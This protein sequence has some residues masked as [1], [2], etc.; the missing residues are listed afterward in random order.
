MRWAHI[1]RITLYSLPVAIVCTG[2]WLVTA[3]LFGPRGGS[4]L[5]PLAVVVGAAASFATALVI[6]FAVVWWS[7][8]TGRYLRI[9]HAW[10]V[11][12]SVVVIS[13]LLTVLTIA[14][15]FILTAATV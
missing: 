1:V 12:V 13:L 8:A 4:V 15:Q 6:P 2:G 9:P 3:A 10:G 7:V 11:G 5:V 14:V